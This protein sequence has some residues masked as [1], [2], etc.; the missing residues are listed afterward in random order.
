M[1]YKDRDP[2]RFEEAEQGSRPQM[3]GISEAIPPLCTAAGFA[4]AKRHPDGSSSDG[5]VPPA[6]HEPPLAA[7][8]RTPRGPQSCLEAYNKCSHE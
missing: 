6:E 4:A 5:I 3:F 7:A 2:Q 1:T 8:V